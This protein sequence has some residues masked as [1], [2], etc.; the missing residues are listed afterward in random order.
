MLRI[1]VVALVVLVAAMFLLP[2]GQRGA[3][4][5]N[6]HCPAGGAAA[7]RR[8]L[9]RQDRPRDSPQRL[10]GRFH[11]AVLR[12]HELPGRLPADAELARAGARR[13]RGAGAAVHAARAVRERRPEPRHAGAH[14]GLFEQLRSR[15]R[16]RDGRR[17]R[18]RSRCS[19]RSVSPSRSTSTAARTTTSCTTRRSMC[20]TRTQSGSPSRLARTIPRVIASDYLRI[21]Q[22]HS[23][24]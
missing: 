11:A 23:G 19:Q 14:R 21:R 13:R 4:A 9:R 16:G 15:V 20:S 3:A 5:A 18:A 2:R 12:L 1:L 22:R 17:R 7:R 8:A 6:S 10:Q 24:G